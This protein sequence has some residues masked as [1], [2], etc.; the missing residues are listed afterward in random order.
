M[1]GVSAGRVRKDLEYLADLPGEDGTPGSLRRAR[2]VAQKLK[3]AGLGV[4]IQKFYPYMADPRDVRVSLAMVSPQ[5]EQLPVKEVRRP[6]QKKFDEISVG[7]NEGTPSANLTKNAIYVNFGRAADY[8]YLASQGI[9]VKDKIVM[10]RYGGSQRSEVPYQAWLHHAAGVLIYSDPQQDG[11]TRGTVYP[12]GPWRAPD[13]I[14]RGTVYRW[15]IYPGDPLTPGREATKNARRIPVS[16]STMGKIPPTTPIGYGAAEPLLKNLTGPVAPDSWQGGLPFKYR[17]GPGGTKV[18]LKINIK[19]APRPSYN[20]IGYLRGTQE[21]EKVTVVGNH[22]DTWAYGAYDNQAGVS[23]QLEVARSLGKLTK[24]GWKP[25]R[26]IA[27]AFWSAEERGIAGSTEWTEMLGTKKMADVIAY[28]NADVVPG[29]NFGASG[30]PSLD[31]LLFD[32]TKRVDWPGASGNLYQAWSGGGTPTVGRPG[33][34]TD[35]MTFLNHF[36]APVISVG[37]GSPGGR[38]HCTCDDLYSLRAFMD[39]DLKYTA[40]V[41]KELGLLAMRLNE[42]D[43][44]P[45]HYSKYATEIG[46]YLNE[47]ATSHVANSASGEIDVKP[48]IKAA[49]RWTA[50]AAETERRAT[51]TL[52]RADAR[53]YESYNSAYMKA[54]RA[55]LTKRGL[56]G[57]ALVRAPGLCSAIPQRICSAETAR[58]V[59]LALRVQQHQD[60]AAL[61]EIA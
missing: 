51:A 3:A 36:G 34:G 24:S 7:Y 14:Q 10:V 1:A 30:V 57:Q 52:D 59:R 26:T 9:S 17:I 35:Y 28:I 4:R 18:H 5:R 25:K 53:K 13:G 20:V 31:Q 50:T 15:T 41:G 11:S 19:Y 23:A 27:L 49:E 22:Y 16:K 6:W 58:T 33:G 56:P 45:F 42:A 40:S 29:P 60:D 43:I 44:L 21:P 12:Q 8:D 2:Y 55:L 47:F 48:A 54:E 46:T 32:T 39:P 38:Y 37:S 61:C